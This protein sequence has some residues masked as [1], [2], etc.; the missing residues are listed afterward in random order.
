MSVL[1]P[2]RSKANKAEFGSGNC[3]ERRSALR[4]TIFSLGIMLLLIG[5]TVLIVNASLQSSRK[6]ELDKKY[7][8]WTISENLTG[9]NTYVLNIRSSDQ[10]QRDYTMGGYTTAQPVDVVLVSPNGNKTELLAFFY[11]EP[12]PYPYQCP[13]P[14][15]IWVEYRTVDSDSLDVDESASWIRFTVKQSGNYAACIIEQTLNWTAGPPEYIVL[16][17][18]IVE[19][20]SPI[21]FP[22]GVI[23]CVV[24]VA[25]SIVGGRATKRLSIRNR[26]NRSVVR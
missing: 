13:H 21:I 3:D 17:R 4:K 10:W 16:Y 18:E 26:K 23:L 8:T 24:G 22:S 7:D 15:L 25:V 14:V 20:V 12:A 2:L 5:L 11:A 1:F 19:S 9:R 6:E